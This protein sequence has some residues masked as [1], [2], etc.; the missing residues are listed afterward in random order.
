[1]NAECRNKY[2]RVRR[3]LLMANYWRYRIANPLGQRRF[4]CVIQAQIGHLKRSF[5]LLGLYKDIKLKR[6]LNFNE[7]IKKLRLKTLLVTNVFPL[8]K[9]F[10]LIGFTFFVIKISFMKIA[11][12]QFFECSEL[13]VRLSFGIGLL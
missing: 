13:S 1:M 2:A 9:L 10:I 11:Y 5:L 8:Y 3:M 12:T 4:I 6:K 7:S